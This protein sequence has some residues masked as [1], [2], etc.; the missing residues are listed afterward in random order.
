MTR[1]VWLGRRSAPFLIRGRH[2]GYL[3]FLA[4]WA[5]VKSALRMPTQKWD[6]NQS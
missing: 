3:F 4:L 5:A 6:L 2:L 1:F